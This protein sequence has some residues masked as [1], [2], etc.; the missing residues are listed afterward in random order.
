MFSNQ[1]IFHSANAT[2]FQFLFFNFHKRK[3]LFSIETTCFLV[4]EKGFEKLIP[5]L[6]IFAIVTINCFPHCTFH[7]L[8]NQQEEKVLSKKT[9]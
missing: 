2:A 3:G 6:G 9:T 5:I 1:F 7:T 8:F 4:S